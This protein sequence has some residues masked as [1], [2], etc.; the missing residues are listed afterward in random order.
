MTSACGIDFGTSNSAIAVPI[1]GEPALVDL[2]HGHATIPTA[3]FF[4]AETN[5]VS[6]GRHAIRNYVEGA[7]GRL[8]RGLK[9]ILG[10]SIVDE[11]TLVQ[12]TA[13]TG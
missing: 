1:G 11:T 3:L 13:T 2:E 4:D 8:M 10:S 9:S 7:E 12:G 6:Y 5:H